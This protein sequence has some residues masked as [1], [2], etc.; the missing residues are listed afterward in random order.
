MAF[1]PTFKNIDKKT[2]AEGGSFS[3]I[4]TLGVFDI[5][6]TVVFTIDIFVAF[7]SSFI[8]VSTGDEI[9]DLKLIAINYVFV[10]T[11]FWVDFIST[12]PWDSLAESSGASESTQTIFKFL[13]I[14]KIVRV[15]RIGKV[16]ADLNYT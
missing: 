16:I 7:F 4:K 14:L 13:G 9:F 8:N 12:V 11:T 1:E 6:T 2:V 15:F 3:I 10:E 5:L